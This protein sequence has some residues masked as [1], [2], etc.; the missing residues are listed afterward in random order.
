MPPRKSLY[1]CT[2]ALKSLLAR[3]QIQI[4]PLA[5]PVPL[6][7]ERVT[8]KIQARSLLAQID[9]AGLLPVEPKAHLAF[10]Q[11]LKE[12]LNRLS[13]EPRKDHEVVRI[14][15][16]TCVARLPWTTWAVPPKVKFMKVHVRK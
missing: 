9:D 16:K 7:A 10:K 15:H 12:L 8:Q 2:P 5:K 1:L 14:A 3:K 6:E 13:D 4:L 11:P